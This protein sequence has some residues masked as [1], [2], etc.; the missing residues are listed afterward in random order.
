MG[1]ALDKLIRWLASVATMTTTAIAI[2][3]AI[4]VGSTDWPHLLGL[5]SFGVASGA[6][7]WRIWRPLWELA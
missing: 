7:V 5:S 3:T 4:D 2:T 6:I 1:T